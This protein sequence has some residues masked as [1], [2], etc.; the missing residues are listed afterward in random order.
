VLR[1]IRNYFTP[2]KGPHLPGQDISSMF[3][4][5]V[6]TDCQCR[7][8]QIETDSLSPATQTHA[9]QFLEV[10]KTYQNG[11][12]ISNVKRLN[13]DGAHSWDDVMCMVRENKTIYDEAGRSRF[14][15]LG[16]AIGRRS[17]AIVPWLR[18]VPNDSYT[19]I[20]CGGLRC[21]F[22]LSV[23]LQ[24]TMTCPNCSYRPWCT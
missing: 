14:R 20:L 12:E 10:V 3:N 5:D 21:I 9:Q 8:L 7:A 11:C 18:M 24:R 19:S 16:R 15:K 2:S 17:D 1:L 6:L 4:H 23:T 13:L 22:E